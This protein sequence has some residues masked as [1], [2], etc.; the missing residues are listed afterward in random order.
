MGKK[1]STLLTPLFAVPFLISGCGTGGTTS[2]PD[3]GDSESGVSDGV[4]TVDFFNQKPEITAQ[5]EELADMYNEETDGNTRVTITTVGSGEGSAGLQARFSS[6]DEPALMMLGGLPEVERYSD[7]LIDVSELDVT[8]TLIDGTLEGGT[9]D[10]IPLG[11]PLNLEGFGWMYNREIFEEAGI[12]PD[13]IQSYDDFA[14]AVE[15]L[16]SQK[17]E[18]GIDEVFAFSGGENYIANQFSANFTSPEFN[19]SIIESYEA[20]ELNWEY[21]D[22]MKKYTDLFNQYNVQPI[23]TV[24]YSRSV[25][26]LFVN[27]KVAMVHQG[28]WIVPTLNDIDPSFAKE[29]LGLLPVY[30]ESDTEGKIIAGAPFYIGV[31]K[32]L[33]DAVV[34]ESKNFLD[35]M[36]T[37]EE[38]KEM[39]TGDLAFVPAQEGYEPEDI[40][41]PVS[42]ELYRALLAGETG[43]MTH[44]QYPDGWFQQV[45]YPEYQKYLNGDQTWE[46]FEMNTA[47]AFK[48]MR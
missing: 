45:L 44:K 36:Y 1:Y 30:G 14:E 24:D 8:D 34:E 35:W 48:E 40:S 13:S 21:G 28:I 2:T 15:T 32:N 25:E 5:L 18:L 41:D 16:D 23:L 37:S 11:I 39:I 3:S 33:D 17:E 4:V 43:A 10:D 26:E 19:E 7:S 47:E 31:N 6:G 46:D 38:G 29:K 20:K 9:I 12:N 27:D 42:Q 22:Q